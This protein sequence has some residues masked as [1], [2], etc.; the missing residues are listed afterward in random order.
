MKPRMFIMFV[1]VVSLALLLLAGNS[2]VASHDP[3]FTSTH[4]SAIH[5]RVYRHDV[6]CLH[7]SG[8]CQS[9]PV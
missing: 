3:E 4:Q 7:Q 1:V 8:A 2:L 6:G 9:I 5:V